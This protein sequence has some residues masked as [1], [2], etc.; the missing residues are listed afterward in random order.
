MTCESLL[1]AVVGHVLSAPLS[2]GGEA[3]ANLYDGVPTDNL[4]PAQEPGGIVQPR[5]AAPS[6]RRKFSPMI[7]RTVASS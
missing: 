7:L 5:Q 3:E 6:T 1:E 4:R 2:S